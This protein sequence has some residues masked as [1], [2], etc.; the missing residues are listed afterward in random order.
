MQEARIAERVEDSSIPLLNGWQLPREKLSMPEAQELHLWLIELD[1]SDTGFLSLLS[2]DEL[3][4][5][6]GFASLDEARRFAVARGAA[7][8]ILGKYLGAAANAIEFAYGPLGKPEI[9]QPCCN[10]RFNLSHA[11]DKALLAVRTDWEVGVDLEP[12]RSRGNMLKIA[13]RVFAPEIAEGLKDLEGDERLHAFF[14]HWTGMEARAKALGK[15]VFSQ[16]TGALPWIGF[17]P[18]A[19]WIGAVA[20]SADLPPIDNWQLFLFH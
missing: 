14:S 7:R 6:E 3:S 2:T 8:S 18:A 10:L 11:G 19:G 4:R 17:R 20:S 16:D 13:G 12:V 1:Q 15:G 5:R 9:Q